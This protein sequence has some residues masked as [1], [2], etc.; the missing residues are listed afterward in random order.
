MGRTVHYRTKQAVAPDELKLLERTV[1]K[2][3]SGFEWKRER[4][5]IWSSAG[6]PFP[7]GVVWGFTKVADDAEAKRVLRAVK[8][9][10]KITPELTWLVCDEGGLTGGRWLVLKRGQGGC[11]LQSGRFKGN[12]CYRYGRERG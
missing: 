3:N 6:F 4:I 9:M 1:A 2:Y 5:K 12:I 10:S 8:E 11:R 7:E